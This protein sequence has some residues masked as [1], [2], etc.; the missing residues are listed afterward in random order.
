M[1]T[2]TEREA[3]QV[4]QAKLLY[5]NSTTESVPGCATRERR[6]TRFLTV[7]GGGGGVEPA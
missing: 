6:T 3:Q 2:V 4:E 1:A 5:Q 7:L